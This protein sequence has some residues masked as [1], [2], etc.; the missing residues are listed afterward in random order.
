MAAVVSGRSDASGDKYIGLAQEPDG[1]DANHRP[2][3][4]NRERLEGLPCSVEFRNHL[5]FAPDGAERTLVLR[6]V[7]RVLPG[8]PFLQLPFAA[9]EVQPHERCCNGEQNRQRDQD[10]RT[11]RQMHGEAAQPL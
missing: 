6:V 2:L 4:E 10:E 5:W 8:D 11:S 3:E 7:Q 9:G 1:G